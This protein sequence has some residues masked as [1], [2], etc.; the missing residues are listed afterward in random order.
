MS[1]VHS[2]ESGGPTGDGYHD[3]TRMIDA[4]VPG[5]AS[6]AW[7][8][9]D[10][11]RILVTQV[12]P[13]SEVS[14]AVKLILN[15]GV[16]DFIDLVSNIQDGSGR[17][18]IR[19]SRS[20]IEHAVN[21]WTVVE[22]PKQAARY[23]D[24]LELGPAL[25]F[26]QQIGADL[27]DKVSR[28]GYLH[29][30]K[31]S[32]QHA[33]ARFEDKVKVYGPSFRRGWA[34]QNLRTRAEAAGLGQ[35]YP[36]YQLASLIAHGS[37][38]GNVGSRSV[39]S[40]NRTTFRTGQALELAPTALEMGMRA[41]RALLAGLQRELKSLDIATYEAG[42]SGLFALW[43]KYARA[44]SELDKELWPTGP[45]QAPAAMLA[46]SRR[47]RWN[48][49][50]H[51]PHLKSLLPA[52]DPTLEPHLEERLRELTKQ[53]LSDIDQY[54]G[55]RRINLVDVFGVQLTVDPSKKSFPD[56]ALMA[57]LKDGEVWE[58]RDLPPPTTTL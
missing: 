43:P 21:M 55:D 1:N 22:N 24:H 16:N 5:L 25:M 20:L 36:Y 42:L 40:Q 49:Y 44:I 28:R 14:S 35:L 23:L 33:R 3:W 9:A 45:V 56:T 30:L 51:V 31:K 7:A 39:D 11:Q 6:A 34:D 38:G 54:F 48:W 58:S 10:S 4:K 46:I 57:T 2:A 18:A 32:G 37:A 12:L 8:A 50:V 53:L 17:P 15:Q 41:Q 26:E 29:A 13:G 52:K 19:A 27:L 47:G